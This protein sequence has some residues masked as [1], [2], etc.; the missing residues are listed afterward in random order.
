M[1]IIIVDRNYNKEIFIPINNLNPKT[2]TLNI[3]IV[4]KNLNCITKFK[5]T[6]SIAQY[7]DLYLILN[8]AYINDFIIASDM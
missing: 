4:K 2:T 3:F 7:I 8:H 1:L 5:L 6:I